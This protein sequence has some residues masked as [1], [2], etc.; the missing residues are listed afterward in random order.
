[1]TYSKEKMD[2]NLDVCIN[3][4]DSTLYNTENATRTCI[5]L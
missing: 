3:I 1:M 2:I 5:V 4:Y